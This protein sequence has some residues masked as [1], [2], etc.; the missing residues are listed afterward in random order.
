MSL[1]AEI[2]KRSLAANPI[3]TD[4]NHSLKSF[5]KINEMPSFIQGYIMSKL[6]L[7]Y[8]K[9]TIQRYIYDYYHFFSFIKRVS[10]ESTLL[11]SDISLSDFLELN[12]EGIQHYI[13]YL[14]IEIENEGTT[15][16]RKISALQSLFDYLVKQGATSSNPVRSVQRPKN[17]KREPIYLTKHEIIALFH[18]LKERTSSSKKQAF[19]QGKLKLR[20]ELVFYL[21]MTTGLRISEL[22]SLS[23]KQIDFNE[24]K[25]KINGKG[26][27]ERVVPISTKTMDL[28]DSFLSSIPTPSRPN[29]PTD[30]LLIGYDFTKKKLINGVSVSSLQKMIKRTLDDAKKDLP[31]LLFKNISAH[32]LRHSFAT[33]LV[34]SGTDV[35]T[36]Q[37]LLGHE[38]VSTTQIYAHVQQE[39]REKAISHLSFD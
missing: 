23:L 15:I 5:N 2:N 36:I 38:S 30:Y 1:F 7:G 31:F 9:N 28:I 22:A 25:L 37:S 13:S 19:Y 20:D 14:A 35:L 33:E 34:A 6:S 18:W 17:G 10:G 24:K 39:A 12:K 16:N 26:N 29:Q 3:N 32:K 4:E 8:S 21:L 27:K 11:F